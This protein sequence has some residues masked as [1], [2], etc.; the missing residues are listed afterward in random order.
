MPDAP[1]PRRRGRPPREEERT[2][3]TLAFRPA[4]ETRKLI[5]AG[6]KEAGHSLSAEIDRRLRQA[7]WDKERQR[8]E[9]DRV[10]GGAHNFTL[11][12]LLARVATGVEHSCGA[13]WQED[14]LV[15]SEVAT[16][17]V[18]LL[19]LMRG[20]EGASVELPLTAGFANKRWDAPTHSRRRG[21]TNTPSAE[22][23]WMYILRIVDLVLGKSVELHWPLVDQ[24]KRRHDDYRDEFMP[25]PEYV[26]RVYGEVG[27][28]AISSLEGAE[29]EA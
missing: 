26:R 28:T 5:E 14:R 4:L 9:R 15:W 11:A 7:Y 1:K 18:A 17:I 2:L 3:P 22:A 29:D 10:F 27:R 8:I 12:F 20:F 13:S 19:Q 25:P 16:A 21:P 23:H 6:A 24:I